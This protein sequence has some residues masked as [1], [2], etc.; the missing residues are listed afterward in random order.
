[1][2]KRRILHKEKISDLVK[3]ALKKI[4]QTSKMY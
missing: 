3:T 2:R 4:S 1:L